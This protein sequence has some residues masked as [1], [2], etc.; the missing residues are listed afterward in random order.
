MEHWHC[1]GYV[2]KIIENVMNLSNGKYV[3]HGISG[4]VMGMYGIMTM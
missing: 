1:D 3:R 2:H 4:N